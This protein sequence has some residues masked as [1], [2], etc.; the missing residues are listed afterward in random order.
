MIQIRKSVFETNSSS[1]HS[2]TLNNTL[3]LAK[4]DYLEFEKPYIIRIFK[5]EEI[6]DW[7]LFT[8]IEDK[9]RYLLTAYHQSWQKEGEF[10]ERIQKLFP[11]TTFC[12]DFHCPYIFEDI[13]Y[14][15]DDAEELSKL[16]SLTDD[17]L[18]NFMI[19]GSIYYYNRDNE[20]YNY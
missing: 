10:M 7:E 13:E 8:S 18:M 3:N 17:E 11:N 20:D 14:L 12:L 16:N 15:F 6:S 1:T 4:Q 9:L 2:L 5:R 19:N